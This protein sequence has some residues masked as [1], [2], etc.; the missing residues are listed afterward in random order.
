MVRRQWK[1]NAFVFLL[2][3]SGAWFGERKGFR[4][5][6][7][8]GLLVLTIVGIGAAYVSC[9][10]STHCC[11]LMDECLV[12][13]GDHVLRKRECRTMNGCSVFARSLE[14]DGDTVSGKFFVAVSGFQVVSFVSAKRE[15]C[16]SHIQ[17]RPFLIDG[18]S[19]WIS[20]I[21]LFH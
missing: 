21:F 13:S 8:H 17:D 1:S 16:L 10:G 3:F 11:T 2:V 19:E 5:L 6:E 20:V 15:C 4:A 18:S 12:L 14:G 9:L 7:V